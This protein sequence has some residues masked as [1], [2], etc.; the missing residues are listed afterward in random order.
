MKDHQKNDR[1]YE[2]EER[3]RNTSSALSCPKVHWSLQSKIIPE[4]FASSGDQLDK[5]TSIGPKLGCMAPNRLKVS[6]V[7]VI[8]R[9]SPELLR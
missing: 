4:G 3:T 1:Y 5:H 6:D 7:A 9:A 8:A 2:R